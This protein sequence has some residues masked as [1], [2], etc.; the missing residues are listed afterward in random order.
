MS[1]YDT[2]KIL[3]VGC[4]DSN[5]GTDRIDFMKTPTTTK[6]AD[7][8]FPLPYEDNTFDEIYANCV[9]EHLKNLGTFSEECYRVLK[10]G[11][12]LYVHTDYAGYI[13]F[14]LLKTHEHNHFLNKQYS[15]GI[16]YGHVKGL[17]SHYHLFVPSHLLNLF[18]QFRNPKISFTY[19]GR[20]RLFRFLLKLLPKRT[21]AIG[22]TF[23][24]I[25]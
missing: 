6:V 25:K 15:T 20:N 24:A 3:N 13:P 4:G 8:N 2:M 22:I 12:K 11:G 19:G 14:H 9:L 1:Q 5:Y 17:D 18:S 23:Q 16:G 21:G 7:A 10:K